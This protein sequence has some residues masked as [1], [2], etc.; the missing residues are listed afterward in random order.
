MSAESG[1]PNTQSAAGPRSPEEIQAE[2]EETREDLGETVAEIADKADV[3]K[4]AKRKVGETKAKVAAKKD[5][6]KQ[7]AATQKEAAGVKVKQVAP[8]SAQ[9]GAQQGAQTA[10]QAAA[11]A[12][13]AVRENPVPTAAIGAFLCGLAIGWMLGRR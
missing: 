11:Q 5:E 9:E 3:K 8:E 1:S 4:Q 6:V 7:K 10:Q 2:I 13:Q 12:S